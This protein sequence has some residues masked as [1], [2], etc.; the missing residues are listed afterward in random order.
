MK[1]HLYL[2]VLQQDVVEAHSVGYELFWRRR[3][4]NSVT[5]G[6]DSDAIRLRIVAPE[7]NVIP[8]LTILLGSQGEYAEHAQVIRTGCH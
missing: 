7:A 5:K 3:V 4:T 8:Q 1:G 6:P 2:S